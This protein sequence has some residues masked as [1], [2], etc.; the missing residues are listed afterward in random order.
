[1]ELS[2]A[3]RRRR[4][5][6]P[7]SLLRGCSARCPATWT[8]CWPRSSVALFPDHEPSHQ[9][10]IAVFDAETGTPLAVMDGTHIT[11]V[12]RGELGGRTRAAREDA[13]CWR[14]RRGC[15][16]LAPRRRSARARSRKF[17]SRADV[18]T[19]DWR[20][21][22]SCR[23]VRAAARR[24]VAAA[25]ISSRSCGDGSPR[26]RT[27]P[28]WARRWTGRSSIPRPCG[29]PA[30]RRVARR[31]L[32]AAGRSFELQGSIGAGGRARRGAR[33]PGHRADDEQSRSTSR[34]ATRSRRCAA[35]SCSA[36][37]DPDAELLGRP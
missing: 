17:G 22:A 27:S 33:G 30:L 18:R 26:E 4:R 24:D 28:R 7:R 25:R 19:R 13:R 20:R 12:D 11:A 34:W 32:A 36:P 6:W 1:M 31:V 35:A 23:V 2:A 9:A 14:A 5:A 3:G 10:L 15:R 29:G 16:A 21:S 37:P 8:A